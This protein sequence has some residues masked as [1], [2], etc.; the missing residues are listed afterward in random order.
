MTAQT[1][2]ILSDLSNSSKSRIAS[3]DRVFEAHGLISPVFHKYQR[4]AH[5]AYD[6]ELGMHVNFVKS[7]ILPFDFVE[8]AETIWRHMAA[9]DVTVAQ[10][11]LKVG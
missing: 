1:L 8:T 2:N 7:S 10:T 9:R 11:T 4:E 5:V 3:F 6:D